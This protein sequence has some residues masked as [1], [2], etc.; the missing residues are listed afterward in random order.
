MWSGKP[1]IITECYTK[2]MDAL[3][4]VPGLTNESGAGWVVPTDL[5]R[6]Y[7]YQNYSL[8]LIESGVCIGFQWYKY[9][10]ND[11]DGGQTDVSNLNSNKGIIDRDYN[12][13]YDLIE[14][15]TELNNNVFALA[16]YFDNKKEGLTNAFEYEINIENTTDDTVERKMILAIYDADTNELVKASVGNDYIVGVGNNVDV[17]CKIHDIPDLDSGK[18]YAK[19]FVWDKSSDSAPIVKNVNI[20]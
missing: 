1:V 10:D 20:K 2:G 15:M 13:Y 18:Y 7:F 16:E 14:K 19:A 11:P 3:E 17:T 12:Y 8:A 6:G 9:A 5:D 4:R